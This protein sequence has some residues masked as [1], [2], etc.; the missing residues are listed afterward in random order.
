MPTIP[1]NTEI[2]RKWNV[3]LDTYNAAHALCDTRMY[4]YGADLPDHVSDHYR[5]ARDKI[6]LE[7]NDIRILLDNAMLRLSYDSTVPPRVSLS[8][9][10]EKF[11]LNKYRAVPVTV[12]LKRDQSTTVERVVSK[13]ST[14]DA[15]RLYK[16]VMELKGVLKSETA[17]ARKEGTSLDMSDTTYARDLRNTRRH[18]RTGSSSIPLVRYSFTRA[19]LRADTAYYYKESDS[20]LYVLKMGLDSLRQQ[21]ISARKKERTSNVTMHSHFGPKVGGVFERKNAVLKKLMRDKVKDM[22]TDKKPKSSVAHVGIELEFSSASSQD[23]LLFALYNAGLRE[24]VTLKSDGSVRVINPKHS[25]HELCVLV[26]EKDVPRVIDAVCSV[27]SRLQCYVNTSCG[28]HVH[29]DMRNRQ[30]K[31]AYARLLKAQHILFNMV[32]ADRRENK[33]CRWTRSDMPFE[34][35]RDDRYFAIN[36]GSYSKHKTIEVRLHG[37]TLSPRRIINWVNL[38]AHIADTPNN[39]A[40]KRVPTFLLGLGLKGDVA[41]Y[42]INAVDKYSLD[43]VDSDEEHI[44]SDLFRA[45]RNNGLVMPVSP[46][47]YGYPSEDDDLAA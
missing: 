22:L 33:F 6:K 12:K 30:P 20:I 4:E 3:V 13:S 7:R 26:P 10:A 47:E 36:S 24:Y 19:G 45:P 9:L 23:D 8:D 44:V 39:I 35:Y 34:E 29:L 14:S 32:P 25:A 17:R 42:V 15:K 37:G 21:I 28:M 5:I 18:L 31:E 1:S 46:D 43:D 16:R 38:L 40:Y 11:Q 27:L 2:R 41:E